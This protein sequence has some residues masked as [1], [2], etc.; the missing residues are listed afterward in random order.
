MKKEKVQKG[1]PEYMLQQFNAARGSVLTAIILTVL[2][3]LLIAIDADYYLLFSISVPYYGVAF[4]MGMD[5]GIGGN[6]FTIAAIVLGLLIVGVY[7]IL[8]LLSKKRRGVMLVAMML[9]IVD[10][11]VLLLLG[12][13]ITGLANILLDLVFHA[14]ILYYLVQAA[15]FGGKLTVLEQQAQSYDQYYDDQY[16]DQY[17]DGPEIR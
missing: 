15:R 1:S 7:F 10:T 16:D 13:T 12:L 6:T 5:M 4:G 11:I 14:V 9:F 17:Y 2:N 3:I 8:W